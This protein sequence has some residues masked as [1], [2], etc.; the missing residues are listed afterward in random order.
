MKNES[1]IGSYILDTLQ[2]YFPW[3]DDLYTYLKVRGFGQAGFMKKALPLIYSDNCISTSNKN[4]NQ[5]KYVINPMHFGKT[6]DQLRW[7]ATDRTSEPI[8][9]AEKPQI[10]I[11]LVDDNLKFRINPQVNGVEQYHLE[12]S[13]MAEFGSMYTNWAV[14][15]LTWKDFKD[16]LSLLKKRIAVTEKDLG[17]VMPKL[18]KKQAQRELMHYAEVPLIS[19]RF[20]MAEFAYARDFLAMNGYKGTAPS[21]VFMNKPEYYEKMEPVLKVGFIET[22]AEQGFEDRK[23]QIALKIAQP[24]ITTSLRGKRCKTKGFITEE[25]PYEN[26]FTVPAKEFICAASVIVRMHALG[27]A[28]KHF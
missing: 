16:A 23:P 22:K 12:Y 14:P 27:K 28:Q 10:T 1:I 17:C 24:K 13:V 25:K 11:S 4:K 5:R 8:I 3:D 2:I 21:L 18:E 26:R 7:K 9:P 19:Y 20:S 15:V 6:H